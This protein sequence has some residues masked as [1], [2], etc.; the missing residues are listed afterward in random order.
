LVRSGSAHLSDLSAAEVIIETDTGMF[1][2]LQIA[3]Q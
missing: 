2:A 3:E 1:F